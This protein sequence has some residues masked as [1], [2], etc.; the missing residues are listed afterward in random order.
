[1]VIVGVPVDPA[2]LNA[3]S[4]IGGNKVLAGSLIGGIPETQKML[5]F[6]AKTQHYVGHRTSNRTTS[7]QH[8][9]APYDRMYDTVSLSTCSRKAKGKSERF[10]RGKVKNEYDL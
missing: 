10:K 6:C 1:M 7:K 3:F 8:M 4:L 9:T 5:D 2:S